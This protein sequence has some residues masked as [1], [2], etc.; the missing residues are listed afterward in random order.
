MGA[1]IR[2]AK[3]DEEQIALTRNRLVLQQARA[4]GSLVP[5]RM[6]VCQDVYRPS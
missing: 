4:V 2:A 3:D 6:H 1:R 5:L